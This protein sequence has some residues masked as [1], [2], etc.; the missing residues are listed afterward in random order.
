MDYTVPTHPPLLYCPF[1]RSPTTQLL[2]REFP[3]TSSLILVVRESLS[4]RAMTG[5]EHRVQM[6]EQGP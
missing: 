4:T 3:P 5:T 2:D 1:A 6:L